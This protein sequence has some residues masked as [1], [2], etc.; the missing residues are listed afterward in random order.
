MPKIRHIA[1]ASQDPEATAEFYKK[2]FDFEEVGRGDS[3]LA[4]G[5]YLSDGTL[6]LAILKFKSDQIGKGLDYVGV[7]HFGV[8]VDD[9]DAWTEKLESLGAECFVRR[10]EAGGSAN[11][12]VKFHGPEGVVFDIADHPWVGSAPAGVETAK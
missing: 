8:L 3:R 5:V 2:A 7:H 4:Q 1:I 12:E 11:F 6:N 10:P 9:V